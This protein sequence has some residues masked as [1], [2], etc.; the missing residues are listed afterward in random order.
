MVA[1]R[2]LVVAA[3]VSA[4]SSADFAVDANNSHQ[5][6]YQPRGRALIP[7]H[8]F[9]ASGRYG[10]QSHFSN[11]WLDNEDAIDAFLY[12]TSKIFTHIN[13]TLTTPCYLISRDSSYTR[14]WTNVEWERH[15]QRSLRRYGRHF[16]NWHTSTT[17]HAVLPFVMLVSI[18]SAVVCFVSQ[19]FPAI[20]NYLR[21]A[22]LKSSLLASF[23]SP[24]ALLLTL[25]TNRALDRV[26]DTRK[27]WGMMT[28]VTRALA[29]MACAYVAPT[30]GPLALLMCRYLAIF[31]WCLKGRLRGEDDEE[32]I[33]TVLPPEEAE[34][35]LQQD[36]ERPI[37]ILSRIRCLIYLAQ[38]GTE[39]SLP[40]PMST[41][42]HMGNRLH[43]LETVVGTC[44]RILGSPIPP[45]FSRMTSRLLCLYLLVLPFALL[46]F[47]SNVSPVAVVLTSTLTAYV[48]CGIDEIGVEL[49]HPFPIMPMQ[50]MSTAAQKGVMAQV[51]MMRSMPKV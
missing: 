50:H 46:G 34:W 35:L 27:A 45:T 36:A 16:F 15:C 7:L 14:S 32:V 18:W 8:G 20:T 5:N 12:D 3:V 19:Q 39:V 43:D 13:N 2:G 21:K 33:R 23:A 1:T 44:N 31:P 37:A 6:R 11:S 10:D 24:I 26:L 17:A 42:L 49:E 40:L 22:S 30:N 48:L 47:S 41:H 51:Q 9:T 4:I 28:R 25:K 38:T 29:G